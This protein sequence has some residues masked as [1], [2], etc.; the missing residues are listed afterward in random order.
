MPRPRM[1]VSY[2]L[3]PRGLLSLL[4]RSMPHYRIGS[5]TAQTELDSSASIMNQENVPQLNIP[6]RF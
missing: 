4:S 1:S 5:V 3:T 6:K 2:W